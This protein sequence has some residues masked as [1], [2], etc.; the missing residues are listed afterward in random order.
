MFSTY[1]LRVIMFAPTAS[2]VVQRQSTWHIGPTTWVLTSRSCAQRESD[3]SSI[4]AS[5]LAQLVELRLDPAGERRPRRP[6]TCR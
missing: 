6:S 2:P 1:E 4:D 3:G 5:Q